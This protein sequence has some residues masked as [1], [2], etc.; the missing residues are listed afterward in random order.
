[1]KNRG[2]EQ[3][4]R[5]IVQCFKCGTNITSHTLYCPRCN[6]RQPVPMEGLDR[7]FKDNT[8]ASV[9]VLEKELEKDPRNYFRHFLLGNALFL[10]GDLRAAVHRYRMTLEVKPDFGDVKLNL[11]YVYKLLD[12]KD[13]AIE[14]LDAFRR[15]EPHSNKIEA[16]QRMLCELKGIPW[17]PKHSEPMKIPEI[18]KPGLGREKINLRRERLNVPSLVFMILIMI[19]VVFGIARKDVLASVY[20][21]TSESIGSFLSSSVDS[22]ELND[23]SGD[24]EGDDSE[25]EKLDGNDLLSSMWTP[26]DEEG[27]EV[28]ED[29]AKAPVSPD[30]GGD[31]EGS[32]PDPGQ[33]GNLNPATDSYWPIN[34]GNTWEFEG[35]ELDRHGRLVEGSETSGSIKVT[36]L[37][38]GGATPI[39]KVVHL[40][41]TS[42]FYENDDG[43]FL[44]KYPDRPFTTG[45]P[46]VVKPVV[47]GESI[48]APGLGQGY[49]VMAEVDLDTPAGLFRTL[50]IKTW[51]LDYPGQVTEIFYAKGVG[52]VKLVTGSTKKGFRIRELTGYKVK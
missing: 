49:E 33:P 8:Q 17:K 52:P 20:N 15:E 3:E 23:A 7:V 32:Q 39:Y 21:K 24:N 10:K 12:E 1:M 11:G 2:K 34:V 31:D 43:I 25:R 28:E 16:A 36:E 38:K 37:A 9:E 47:I 30:D 41:Q 14:M 13:N 4:G 35:Y 45:L 48:S 26:D 40:G 29:P 46:Q 6:R 5:E 42:Y 22:S 19:L 18:I 51:S 44:T 50:Q 27:E